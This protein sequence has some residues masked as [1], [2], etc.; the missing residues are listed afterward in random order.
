ML[1]EE[2]KEELGPKLVITWRLPD[3]GP[4]P[5]TVQQ[6]LYLYAE[7]GPLT[8]TAPDNPFVGGTHHRRLVQDA[9]QPPADVGDLR[10]A[11]PSH[12]RGCRAPAPSPPRTPRGPEEGGLPLWPVAWSLARGC[13]PS[14]RSLS[15]AV[16]RRVRVGST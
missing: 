5:A 10:A 8:Y 16:G 14:P 11:V 4:T 9:D 7:G 13:A 3:G 15:G 1:A 6:E 12:A 2:P